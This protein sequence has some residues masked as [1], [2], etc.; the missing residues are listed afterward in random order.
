VL[1]AGMLFALAGLA[2]F[3]TEPRRARAA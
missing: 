2:Y 1:I 3:A